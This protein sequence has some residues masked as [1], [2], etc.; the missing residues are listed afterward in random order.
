[1]GNFCPECGNKL[2]GD[3]KYC[4]NCGTPLCADQTT[5]IEESTRNNGTQTDTPEPVTTPP[6]ATSQVYVQPQVEVNNYGSRSNA[7]GCAGF[8]FA[9]LGIFTSIVPIVN[10]LSPIFSFLGLL[11]SFI[12]MFF[13]PR[14][15]AV[16]GFLLSI[17]DL[18]IIVVLTGGLLLFFSS[19]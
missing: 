14:V 7:A 11:L 13:R 3:E 8:T 17:I 5:I 16:L 1:M 6:V 4:G 12:G 19:L 18:I 2:Q 9:L 15:L 10:F